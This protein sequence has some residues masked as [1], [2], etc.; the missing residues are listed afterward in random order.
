MSDDDLTRRFAA[1]LRKELGM[2]GD[3]GAPGATT[4]HVAAPSVS[5]SPVIKATLPMP[6]EPVEVFDVGRL[7]GAFRFSLNV[8]ERDHN[9]LIKRATIDPTEF[10]PV[11]ENTP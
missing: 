7:R 2:A 3:A 5:V 10:V 1:A 4:V 8:T 6:T 11:G 9:G